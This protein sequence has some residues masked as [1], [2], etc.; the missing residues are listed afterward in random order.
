MLMVNP[1]LPVK[2]VPELVAYTKANPGKLSYGSFGIGTYAH[3]SMEELKQKTGMDLQHVPYKGAAPGLTGLLGNEV[4][5]LLLNLSSVEQ[6]AKNGQVRLIA[7]ATEKRVPVLPDLPTI[8]ESVPGFS[9]SVWFGLWGPPKMSPELT[10]K[11]YADVS[12]ALDLPETKEFFA[13]NT[14]TRVGL[15]PQE[16]G[17]LVA[18]DLKHWTTLINAVGAKVE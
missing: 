12:K 2:T 8:G 10:A 6:Y 15:S 16:F 4:S 1:S 11:V 13:T 14:L 5:V 9:T 18:S 17:G 7:A 3:L